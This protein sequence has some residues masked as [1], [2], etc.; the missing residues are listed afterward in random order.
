MPIATLHFISNHYYSISSNK[1]Q[2]HLLY[3]WCHTVMQLFL[4]QNRLYST[5]AL[6][7]SFKHWKYLQIF[8]FRFFILSVFSLPSQSPF[9]WTQKEMP[10]FFSSMA[11]FSWWSASTQCPLSVWFCSIEASQYGRP[12][13]TMDDWQFIDTTEK[14]APYVSTA[15]T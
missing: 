9:I 7:K 4:L 1:L 3:W 12:P 2:Y 10:A 13:C 6:E 5:L 15:T 11:L 14:V 8:V